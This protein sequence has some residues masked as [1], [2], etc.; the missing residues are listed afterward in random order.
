MN[1]SVDNSEESSSNDGGGKPAAVDTNDTNMAAAELQLP[2][3]EVEDRIAA[4]I[5][6]IVALPDEPHPNPDI[7]KNAELFDFGTSKSV[8]YKCG[9]RLQWADAKLEDGMRHCSWY[10]MVGSCAKS[11]LCQGGRGINLDATTTKNATNHLNQC[12]QVTSAK[13]VATQ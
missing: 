8:I 13:T 1:H 9:V 2:C 5:A 3:I 6:L 11:T 4:F 12:H 7:P 10:C